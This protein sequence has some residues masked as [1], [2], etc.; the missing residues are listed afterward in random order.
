MG[1]DK[2]PFYNWI[3]VLLLNIGTIFFLIS[4]VTKSG[5]AFSS[6]LEDLILLGVS[7]FATVVPILISHSSSRWKNRLGYGIP[8]LSLLPL[9]YFIYDYFTC[10]GKFCQLGPLVYGWC[11]GLSAIIFTVFY[12]I[13]VYSKKWSRGFVLSLT[14]LVPILIVG[15]LWF[16]TKH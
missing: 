10:T 13:G 5:S 16:I 9:L 14:W 1:T 2:R 4:L 8:I 3:M 6:L 15:G 7:L 11:L 12:T